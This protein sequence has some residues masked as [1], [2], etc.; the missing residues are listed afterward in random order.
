MK[1][2]ITEYNLFFFQFYSGTWIICKCLCFLSD[3]HR[4][5]KSLLFNNDNNNFI[6][7]DYDRFI[8]SITHNSH[9]GLMWNLALDGSGLPILP[10]TNSCGGGCR[11]VAQIN[12]DGT[13]SVNQE[14]EYLKLGPY[15]SVNT[16]C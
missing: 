12:S 9:S 8:G 3:L 11:G 2:R 10:T 13:Y 4:I 6:C 5:I 16:D 7:L 14:C 1:A 15:F